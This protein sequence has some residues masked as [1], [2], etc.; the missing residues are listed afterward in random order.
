[1]KKIFLLLLT[2][3]A[4]V[5]ADFK[6]VK[7]AEFEKMVKN[8]APIIDIRTPG[9]W[10]EGVIPGSHKIMFFDEKGNYDIA[11][12]MEK[13]TKVVKDKNS[14]FILVCR[15]SSRT[16]VVG[17]FLA[18]QEGYLKTRDLADGIMW[19]WANFKKPLEK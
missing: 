17:K 19:G 3:Q 2:L 8:G 6:S 14:P 1:M 12:F 15:T 4:L 13:F 10:K 11:K 7:T 16:K 18:N 5:F 9:E